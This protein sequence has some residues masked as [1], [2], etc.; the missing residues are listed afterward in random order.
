[1]WLATIEDVRVAPD[2]RPRLILFQRE[3]AQALRDHFLG[4]RQVPALPDMTDVRVL[5]SEVEGALVNAHD[6]STSS[7]AAV[8]RVALAKLRGARA[9]VR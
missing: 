2:V 5:L 6:S 1:M 4:P 3:A 8:L 9:L 7:T